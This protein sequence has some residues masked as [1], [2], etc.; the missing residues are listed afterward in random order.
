MRR[1]CDGDEA[2][3]MLLMDHLLNFSRKYLPN[4]RGATQD[5]PLVLTSRLIP[6]EVD[7]MVFDMDTVW[8]YPL[9]L[10][11]A[12]EQW[13]YPWDVKI[14]IINDRLNKPE[15]YEGI[16]FTHDTT[17]INL[18]VRCSSYKTIPSMQE[19]VLAQMKVA[20]KIR[21]VDHNDV[22]RLIIERHFL[23]DIKGN[24]RKFSMQSFR[25]VN[26]NEIFRRPPLVGKC[27]YCNG[28]IIFTIAEGSIKKYLEPAI[29]LA[30]KYSLPSY[31]Q[32]SLELLKSR[33]DSVF[34]VD[35][36]RQEGL[37]KWFN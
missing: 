13:K 36:E 16:G 35:P 37:N 19:K 8:E 26:C 6:S 10:Y 7:D 32:Q 31:L 11:E 20:E 33:I 2:A 12:A 17:D 1:D 14:E 28:K 23:R 15:Q 27:T 24:L 25:C 3:V 18:G 21:A 5:A 29:D 30:K 9:E 4:S 34:G 22:A